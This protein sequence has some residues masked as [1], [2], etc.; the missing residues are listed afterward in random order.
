MP[1][2]LW[3]SVATI[4][5]AVIGL[6]GVIVTQ[7]QRK[8]IAD[9]QSRIDKYRSTIVECHS[10]IKDLKLF[11]DLEDIWAKKLI[12][13]RKSES[14]VDAERKR[15][16]SMLPGPEKMGDYGGRA[17]INR[18]REDINKLLL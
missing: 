16:R 5:A 8:Q 11:R 3:G 4:I 14:S 12:E 7:R 18:L 9:Y 2:A 1:D 6:I 13:L 15:M 17:R 10:A